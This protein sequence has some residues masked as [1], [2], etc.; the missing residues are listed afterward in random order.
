MTRTLSSDSRL[1]LSGKT[2]LI[3]GGTTG[4][5]RATAELFHAHGARVAVTGQDE[6]RL[7]KAR[8]ELPADVVVIRSDARSI[9]DADALARK[10]EAELGGL[11]V[12]FLNTGIAKLAPFSAVDARRSSRRARSA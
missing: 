12:L 11:D 5:G 3:T 1:I 7:A 9:A 8:A 10:V 2:A 4:I 6:A